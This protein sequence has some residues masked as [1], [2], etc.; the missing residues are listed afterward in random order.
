MS[1]E[2][3]CPLPWAGLHYGCDGFIYP[4]CYINQ[5]NLHEYRLGTVEAGVESAYNSQKLRDMRVRMLSGIKLDACSGCYRREVL[6]YESFR[7]WKNKQYATFDYSKTDEKGYYPFKGFKYF[8]L[9]ISNLCNLKC[10]ICNSGSSTGWYKDEGIIGT[11]QNCFKDSNS[12]IAEFKKHENSIDLMYFFGGEPFLIKQHYDLLDY[13]YNN[14]KFNIEIHYSTNLTVMN[15]KIL[16]CLEKLKHFKKVVIIGSL[17]GEGKKFE[18]LRKNSSWNLVENNIKTFS[19]FTED[20]YLMPSLCNLNI[21]SIF[22]ILQKLIENKLVKP[23]NIILNMVFEPSYLAYTN[24]GPKL[25]KKVIKKIENFTN[26]LKSFINNAT[27]NSLNTENILVKLKNIETSLNKNVSI[28]LK[29][30]FLKTVQLDKLR[31]ENFIQI[32]PEFYEDLKDE[33]IL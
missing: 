27:L 33:R 22:D 9:K 31:G 23:Q 4:C 10:R 8:E 21:F 16:D 6:G 30:F 26:F 29:D 13:L 18:F 12:L 5:K 25:R 1:N 17:D 32:F 7:Q 2:S 11:E 24:L 20:F 14:K 28:N 15:N 3:I 19:N